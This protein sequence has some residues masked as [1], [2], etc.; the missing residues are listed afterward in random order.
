[1]KLW[2]SRRKIYLINKPF[3]YSFIIFSCTVSLLSLCTFYFAILYFF[4]SFEQR[5]INLGIPPEH[6][7]FRYIAEEKIAMNNIFI[8]ASII[9]L[10]IT[11][12][13]AL[14]L[15]HRVAGPLYRLRQHLHQISSMQT[16]KTVKFRRGDFFRELEE[17]FNFFIKETSTYYSKNSSD[18]KS[19]DEHE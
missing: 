6:I 8:V 2:G 19:R 7:F 16:L 18:S 13:G 17:S 10:A 14:V 9:V 15:S 3:Q 4:W 11:T 12:L 1:M 5:G